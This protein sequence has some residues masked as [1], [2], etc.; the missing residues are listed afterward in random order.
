MPVLRQIG[1][2]SKIDFLDALEDKHVDLLEGYFKD[3]IYLEKTNCRFIENY[4][5]SLKEDE[6]C[7]IL[8]KINSFPNFCTWRDQNYLHISFWR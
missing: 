1:K 8:N 5:I 6:I 4:K 7:D 3:R 2:K